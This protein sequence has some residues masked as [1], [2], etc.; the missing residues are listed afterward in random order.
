MGNIKL[1]P[2]YDLLNNRIHIEDKDFA[3][4]DEPLPKHL[5]QGNV[6]S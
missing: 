2:A 4:E 6:I 3:L 1:S 5:A